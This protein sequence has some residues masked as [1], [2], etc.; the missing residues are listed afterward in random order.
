MDHKVS[1][2]LPSV[3]IVEPSPPS[4]YNPQKWYNQGSAPT[5]QGSAKPTPVADTESSQNTKSQSTFVFPSVSSS[6]NGNSPAHAPSTSQKEEV[7]VSGYVTFPDKAQ[8]NKEDQNPNSNPRP[9]EEHVI[10]IN[11]AD[12]S[13]KEITP[14][15]SSNLVENSVILN[16]SGNNNNVNN[17]N[18]VH[19][20][21]PNLPQLSESLTPPAESRPSR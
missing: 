19:N 14:I 13:I 1:V 6:G 21:N 8:D 11:Q 5:N 20:N 2:A 7:S 18:N 10:V 16:G 15:G 4:G 17:Q 3:A 12:G 9:V